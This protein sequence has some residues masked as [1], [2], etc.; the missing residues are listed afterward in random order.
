VIAAIL[1]LG[2][3]L[4]TGA[5]AD[6]VS[7]RIGPAKPTHVVQIYADLDSPAAA[8]AMMVLTALRER[9]SETVALEFHH[10]A[11]KGQPR[12]IDRA[13]Y[14][15]EAQGQGWH[16]AQLLLAN[17]DQHEYDNLLAMGR[18]LRLEMDAYTLALQAPDSDRLVLSDAASAAEKKLK[19]DVAVL[20]DGQPVDGAITLSAL[21]RLIS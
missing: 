9:H 11:P 15:A 3:A 10:L 17:Q 7:P 16:M 4:I 19:S 1:S 5:G 21:E 13:V 8:R 18:Q 14:A 2:V 20:V 6:V 12:T